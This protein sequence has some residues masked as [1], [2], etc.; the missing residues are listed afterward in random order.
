MPHIMLSHYTDV[1][2]RLV[3]DGWLS[4]HRRRA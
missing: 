2:A 3:E 4:L 1:E